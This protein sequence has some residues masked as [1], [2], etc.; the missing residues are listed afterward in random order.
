MTRVR[1]GLHRPAAR[2]DRPA[3]RQLSG[4]DGLELRGKTLYVVNGY[5]GDEVVVLRLSGD[6]GSATTTGV[7]AETSPEQLDR[8]TTA[9][10]VAG[11]LYVVNG[12]FSIAGPT[13]E[14]FVTRL[15]TR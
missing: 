14:N 15:P 3:D 11:S 1:P 9:A 7:I 8:P 6:G 5:G 12:R 4:G 10:L 2:P 13:T